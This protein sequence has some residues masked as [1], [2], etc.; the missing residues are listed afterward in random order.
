MY[1]KFQYILSKN[2][3]YCIRIDFS[4]NTTRSVG[5][6]QDLQMREIKFPFSF[7]LDTFSART[8]AKLL[9]VI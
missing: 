4:I 7:R 1:V 3:S 6:Y 2:V 9:A 8:C 5:G